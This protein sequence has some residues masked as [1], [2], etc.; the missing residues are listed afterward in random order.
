M[1]MKA[2]LFWSISLPL[3]TARCPRRIVREDNEV[4]PADI[5]YLLNRPLSLLLNRKSLKMKTTK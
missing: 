3:Y 5:Q 1:P 4:T 2:G